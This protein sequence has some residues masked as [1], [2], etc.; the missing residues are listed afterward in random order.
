MVFLVLEIL[1]CK[2]KEP[3]FCDSERKINA[4]EKFLINYLEIKFKIILIHPIC[5]AK[6][7]KSKT[8]NNFPTRI[9]A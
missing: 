5:Q 3:D 8:K 2:N 9:G 7:Q 4:F 1:K 6:C